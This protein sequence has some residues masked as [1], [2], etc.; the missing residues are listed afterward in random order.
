MSGYRKYKPANDLDD[1]FY[2]L[3]RAKRFESGDVIEEGTVVRLVHCK[4]GIK[5]YFD[6]ALDAYGEM[7]DYHY[8]SIK[9]INGRGDYHKGEMS[10]FVKTDDVRAF[11]AKYIQ[12]EAA[13][14]A[15]TKDARQKINELESKAMTRLATRCAQ[16]K[17]E[18]KIYELVIDAM[19]AL[20]AT[21]M[22]GGH[23]IISE[24]NGG[25]IKG[26]IIGVLLLFVIVHIFSSWAEKRCAK[27]GQLEDIARGFKLN[28]EKI[29]KILYD[30]DDETVMN[31]YKEAATTSISESSAG[32]WVQFG[33]LSL[34][35]TSLDETGVYAE[36][37]QSDKKR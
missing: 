25:F 2:K 11:E 29:T 19:I 23:W 10:M 34:F 36:S 4:D 8:F 27:L 22:I 14:L 6:Y 1:G 13:D 20:L 30:L 5:C 32:D 35:K 24:S 9:P 15:I 17:H 7:R 26:T 31:K 21:V 16:S 28:R 18:R 33:P 12:A 3:S 37:T